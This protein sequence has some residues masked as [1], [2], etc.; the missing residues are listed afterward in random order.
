MVA[1]LVAECLAK[2]MSMEHASKMFELNVLSCMHLTKLLIPVMQAA[3]D[4]D[5]TKRSALVV[6]SSIAGKIASPIA[7]CYAGAA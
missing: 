1:W 7:S 4:N 5:P 3:A 6:T 2:D